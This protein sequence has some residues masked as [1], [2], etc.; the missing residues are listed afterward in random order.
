MGILGQ[1]TSLHPYPSI[2]SA[3][4][5]KEATLPRINPTQKESIWGAPWGHLYDGLNSKRLAL[6]EHS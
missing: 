6:I 1:S 5:D 3:A 2:K 4:N